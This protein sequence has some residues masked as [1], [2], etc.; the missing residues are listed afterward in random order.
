[1]HWMD[2][3]LA[4]A[5]LFL[6]GFEGYAIKNNVPG[7][8]ISERTRVYFRIKRGVGK[9]GAFIFL[10]FVGSFVAWFAAHIVGNAGV[11]V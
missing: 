9:A 2:I 1:M 5:G 6:L 11:V 4:V 7:D 3:V 10:A 8:T